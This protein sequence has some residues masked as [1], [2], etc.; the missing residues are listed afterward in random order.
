MNSRQAKR[1]LAKRGATFI[2]GKGGHLIVIL[3]GDARYCRNT[4]DRRRLA[5]DFG[6]RF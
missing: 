6:W 5:K 3:N 4:A 1:Y 2:P